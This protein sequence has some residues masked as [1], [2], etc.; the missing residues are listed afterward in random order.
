MNEES[1]ELG[2]SLAALLC[3]L[4]VALGNLIGEVPTDMACNNWLILL[5]VRHTFKST[6]RYGLFS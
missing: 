2:R 4:D 3:C 5:D 1:L 6:V